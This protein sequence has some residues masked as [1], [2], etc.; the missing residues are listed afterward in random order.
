MSQIE[1]YHILKKHAHS[2][3]PSSWRESVITQ[4]KE[5]AINQ[6]YQLISEEVSYVIIKSKDYWNSRYLKC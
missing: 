1:A 6:V 3:R 4:S 5:D 2:R